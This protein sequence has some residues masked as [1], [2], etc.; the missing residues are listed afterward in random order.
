M[1]GPTVVHVELGPRSY[2]VLI[3]PRVLD[4]I[5]LRLREL[6]K[7]RRVALVSDSTV[8]ELYG[9]RADAQLARGDFEVFPLS[10]PAGESSKSW[11]LAGELLEAFA[12]LGL[13]RGD[14]VVALG[15]GVVGDLAGFSAAVYLRGIDFVQVPTS[16]LAQV[17]SSIGGKTGVDLRAGKN[18]AGA[19]KQ[20]RLVLSDTALLSSLP[21][22]EW[23]NG[24]AEVA[25]SAIIEGD[26][27]TGW[28]EHSAGLLQER[29]ERAVFE[30]V[31]RSA[32]F[33]A[34]VVSADEQESA[35]RECLNYGH[36]LGHAI[37]KVAGY[38]VVGHGRAVAEGMRFAS[39]LAVEL[40]DASMDFV[41]RQ[42]R[43]LDSLG[44]PELG[45]AYP[46][47][48]LL[49]AMRADK[50]ARG[51]EVRFVLPKGPGDWACH[52][53]PDK[54]IRQHLRAWAASKR[55]E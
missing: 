20:P 28:L 53:V 50:K 4:S 31:T 18:L 55:E 16:L 1:S 3:G 33:K 8:A 26:D 22:E 42:D 48:E 44:L 38:G 9:P 15:G 24:L 21:E 6:S 49:E 14:M 25:K 43:L 36:T 39:R 12:Q 34:R 47:A 11:A 52:A 27:F 51:G 41:L 40:L 10:V 19:F 23:A 37:E 32:R 45:C 35:L 2:D 29:D 7:A 46:P 30:A 5:G 13:E 17:D 54:T